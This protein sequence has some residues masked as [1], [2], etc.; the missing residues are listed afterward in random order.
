MRDALERLTRGERLRLH[1]RALGSTQAEMAAFFGVG[2]GHFRGWEDDITEA[3][4]VPDVSLSTLTLHEMCLLL[5]RRHG[6]TLG[7]VAEALGKTSSWV[8][9]AE[10]GRAGAQAVVDY[11]LQ[12]TGS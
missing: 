2:L 11:L 9:Y 3:P 6:I 1:R 7:Q 5:R 10:Q 4:A 8:H 12:E